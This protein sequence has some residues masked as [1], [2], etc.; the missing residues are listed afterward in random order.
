MAVS[1]A[2]Q[3]LRDLRR[4]APE[5]LPP[6]LVRQRWF[7]GKA[8][9]IGGVRVV[10]VVPVVPDRAFIVLA[11]VRYQDGPKETYVLPLWKADPS[12]AG[13][14]PASGEALCLPGHGTTPGTVLQDGRRLPPGA[15]PTCAA[16]LARAIA[17]PCPPQPSATARRQW[18]G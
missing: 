7:G 13:T 15:L 16:L 4:C 18:R 5:A 9:P 8:R 3:L 6:Y 17:M 12:A 2:Q 10:D 1:S 14:H 11:E